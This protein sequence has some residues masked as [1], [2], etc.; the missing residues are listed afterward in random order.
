MS[1]LRLP[2]SKDIDIYCSESNKDLPRYMG[3]GAQGETRSVANLKALSDETE[4]KEE[5]PF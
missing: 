1:S 5:G 2:S 4:K 3:A